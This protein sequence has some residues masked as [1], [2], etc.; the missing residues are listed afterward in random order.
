[1]KVNLNLY[2]NKTNDL[3]IVIDLLRASTTIIVALKHFT[4]VIPVNTTEKAF[5]MK[6]NSDCILAGEYMAEKIEGF[7][8]SNSPNIIKDTSGHTLVLKT[9]NGT[10]VLE[11]IKNNNPETKVLI[12]SSINARAIA[13]ASLDLAQDEI[14]LIMAGV[15]EV[16]VMEDFVGAGLIINELIKIAQI[17]DI[18]LELSESAKVAQM[19]TED[20]I[21]SKILID[22]SESAN[23]LRKLNC[24]EDIEVCESINQLDIVPIY[25]NN[26]IHHL[27]R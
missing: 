9:T 7:D 17:K 13:E 23:R 16:F 8:F 10:K 22:T 5:T 25:E 4:R 19:I 26:E 20:E 27:K 11:N 2:E 18:P 24:D 21:K 12:G 1:M 15:K 3:A 6:E 14:E